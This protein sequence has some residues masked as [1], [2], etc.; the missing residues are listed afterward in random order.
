M[1]KVKETHAAVRSRQIFHFHKLS[2]VISIL[3]HNFIKNTVL[4]TS[5]LCKQ[6]TTLHYKDLQDTGGARLM[7]QD[8]FYCEFNA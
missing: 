5:N 6:Y 2:V 8:S 4:K 1:S 3:Y 7:F